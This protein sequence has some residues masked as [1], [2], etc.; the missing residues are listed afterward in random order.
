MSYF[1]THSSTFQHRILHCLS[2][3]CKLNT[4][5][6]HSQDVIRELAVLQMTAVTIALQYL[7]AVQASY[8]RQQRMGAHLWQ[9][10]AV[11]IAVASTTR[12]ILFLSIHNMLFA[13]W[14]YVC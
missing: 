12:K 6:H 9:M 1:I 8:R 2:L 14:E 3:N 5:Q 10:T 11:T 7:T 13:E 4:E